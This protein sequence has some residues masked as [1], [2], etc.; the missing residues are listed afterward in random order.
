MK[1]RAL[2]ASFAMKQ[3][4]IRLFAHQLIFNRGQMLITAYLPNPIPD[5]FP[6]AHNAHKEDLVSTTSQSLKY[7]GRNRYFRF[8][9]KIDLARL[10]EIVV[11]D[12]ILE[13]EEILL[14]A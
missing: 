14:V 4:I 2:S 8:E 1:E 6:A 11:E 13:Q 12:E 10:G 3:E 5:E 7:D 9:I